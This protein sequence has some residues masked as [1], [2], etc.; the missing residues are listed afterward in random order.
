MGAFASPRGGYHLANFLVNGGPPQAHQ[1]CGLTSTSGP[2]EVTHRL[3]TAPVTKGES[4]WQTLR[5]QNDVINTSGP[6]SWLRRCVAWVIDQ[7]LKL[8]FTAI[9]TTLASAA[10]FAGWRAGAWAV[11]ANEVTCI[12]HEWCTVRGWTLG[13][14]IVASIALAGASAFFFVLAWRRRR[15]LSLINS[16]VPVA[17]PPAPVSPPSFDPILVEDQQFKLRWR[18]LKPPQDWM[19]SPALIDGYSPRIVQRI[20]DG[21]FHGVEGCGERLAEDQETYNSPDHFKRVCPGCDVVLFR[22]SRNR[23]GSPQHLLVW[24][25]R[26]QVLAE[27]QRMQRNGAT[28]AGPRVVLERPLYWKTMAAR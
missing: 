16:T 21:P 2:P 5:M 9:C 8:L 7:S 27:L 25:T 3:S 12:Q 15:A 19:D 28:I 14:L 22:E 26:G 11:V 10:L 1:K 18:I 4:I 17:S 23:D 13:A 24:D 6:P 20:L